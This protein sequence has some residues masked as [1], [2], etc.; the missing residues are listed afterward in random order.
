MNNDQLSGIID[1]FLFTNKESGYFVFILNI[2]NKDKVTVTGTFAN[3]QIGQE[4]HLEG[5]WNF[6]AK[7]GKQFVTNSYTT[8]LPTSIVGIKKY[9]G[10]GF[11]K[12]V[13]KV[14]AEKIVNFFKEK[15]LEIIDKEP[16]KLRHVEG[17]GS[18]RIEQIK[19]SWVDQKFIAKI[20]VFLQDNG[21]TSTFATKIYKKYGHEAIAKLTENP[22]RLTTDIWGIGFKM[23]D[24]IAQNMGFATGSM[25]RIQAGIMHALNQETS[26]GH[27]Y[28]TISSIKNS[29]FQLLEL[30]P[31]LHQKSIKEALTSLYNQDKIKLI[32]YEKEHYITTAQLYHAEKG[33]A[34]KLQKIINSSSQWSLNTQDL[35][36]KLQENMSIP[37][38]EDQQKGIL[39][40]IQEKVSI[41]TGGPGTGKTTLLSTLLT[42][43]EHHKISYK[44]AA[45]TGRAAKRMAE[46]TKRQATTI[47]RLLE[48]DPAIMNFQRN[49]QNALQTDMLIIDEASMLDVFLMHSIVKA[50]SLK[51]HLVLIGDVDQ[52]PSVGPGNILKDLI[53]SKKTSCTQLV[54]IFRQAQNS[55]I[56]QNAH[57]IN[58]GEFPSTSIPDCKQDFYFIKSEQPEKTFQQIK[59]ILQ[60]TK[61]KFKISANNITI[62]TPMNK[63]AAGTHKLNHDLQQLLNKNNSKREVSFAGTTYKENDRVMQIRNNYDKKVFN[64]D[65]GTIEKIDIEEKNV[66]INFDGQYTSYNFDELNELTLAYAVTIHKSQG[67]EYDAIII[68]IFMQ[69]FMLLQRNL[70]YTAIT[71]AKKLCIFIGQ[72]KAIA[73]GIKNTKQSKRIT[74]LKI[75]LTENLSCR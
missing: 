38:N 36:K 1:K 45:P 8:S 52:L 46:G 21:V 9:L 40:S 74:F 27:V 4:I 29:T 20:M 13:G 60:K 75:F 35:Y 22:Y 48:F 19:R 61:S 17:I 25:H 5:N 11:I 10:S 67:S 37:L 30:D 71:R 58:Q 3:I 59:A 70:I 42:L 24:Q 47:H 57:L 39:S 7:F 50:T 33:I 34:Q 44:L 43:L 31:D 56:I 41:I 69:H 26:N 32:T 16:D 6:H 68:P 62:L 51:T 53:K 55:M 12:G 23:A 73:M 72:P 66:T 18:K 14:Y 64:G 63:G 2:K 28:Q 65:I 15:T 49:E 54:H